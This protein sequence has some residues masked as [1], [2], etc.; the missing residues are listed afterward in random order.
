MPYHQYKYTKRLVA[1]LSTLVS[2][3]LAQDLNLDAELISQ[4]APDEEFYINAGDGVE[5]LDG[6]HIVDESLETYTF[7]RYM[8]FWFG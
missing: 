7:V 2:L 4:L 6:T 1:I 5:E 8:Y 3:S